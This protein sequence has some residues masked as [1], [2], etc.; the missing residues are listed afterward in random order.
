MNDMTTGPAPDV[1]WLL[2][3]LDM[4]ASLGTFRAEGSSESS[5]EAVIAAARP[6]LRRLAN[7]EE[8]AFFLMEADGLGFRLVDAEPTDAAARLNEEVDAQVADGVFAW[9]IQ[10]NAPVQVPARTCPGSQVVLHALATRSRIAG[11]FLGIAPVGLD[12]APDAYQKLLSILLSNCAGALESA[13]LYHELSDYNEGLERVVEERT[14]ELVASNEAAQ[15]ANR[16]K[17]EFLASMSHELR[18]PMN[19]VIGMASLLLDT[20]L[21]AEQ[22]DCAE[23][24]H[25]S[26]LSLLTLVNDLLD[27][28]KIEAGRLTLD[29]V[30]FSLREAIETPTALL[31][32]RAGERGLVLASRVAPG[33]PDVVFGDDGRFRQIVTNLLGNA[34]KFTEQG[35]VILSLECISMTPA[36]LTVRLTVQD[37]GIG[38]PAGKWDHIFERFTQVDAST[39]RKYGGTGLGLAIC[40]ELAEMMGGSIGVES[41]EG[42]GSTFWC[43]LPFRLLPESVI[44]PPALAGRRFLVVMAPGPERDLVEE[45]LR[46]EMADVELADDAAAVAHQ[47]DIASYDALLLD[48]RAAY[49]ATDAAV[50][51]AGLPVVML[52]SAFHRGERVKLPPGVQAVLARPYRRRELFEALA[53]RRSSPAPATTTLPGGA[54]RSPGIAAPR[55]LLVDDSLVN[56]KVGSSMLRRLNCAVELAG[57]G[58]EALAA[59]ERS[60]FDLVLMDCQMPE[61]DGFSATRARRRR[62]AAGAPR[63]TIAAMTAHAMQGDRERCLAAGMDDY[64]TKPVSSERIAELL[65]RWLPGRAGSLDHP[66]PVRSPS[67]VVP[68]LDQSIIKGLEE[69]EEGGS[70]GLVADVVHL[71]TEQSERHL[72][73]IASAVAEGKR[74]LLAA[75]L[76]ALRGSASSVGASR[77]AQVCADQEVN[78]DADPAAL[79]EWLDRLRRAYAE[80]R[81]ELGSVGVLKTA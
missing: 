74:V 77:L 27:L 25:Q 9:A 55:V 5:P 10:R 72:Q 44:E 47:L 6:V 30:P 37:T 69:L 52:T 78:P 62:E 54:V 42:A 17:S 13:A 20:T 12:Q 31:A 67:P 51:R 32:A 76:H 2:D 15:M 16:A 68:V 49:A 46:G 75:H 21:D 43:Q 48:D 63:Q 23:T 57:N 29:P 39:T 28:S 64:V 4:V 19:G 50:L 60:S 34:V 11:M 24:V 7:F 41:V 14:R 40:R 81:S 59:M 33:M 18:T 38:I 80:A 58:L 70:P 45:Q 8:S 53:D 3:A 71:F 66:A 26:A 56:Q 35:E 73:S 22:R 36:A 79:A 1:R 65:E 61:L